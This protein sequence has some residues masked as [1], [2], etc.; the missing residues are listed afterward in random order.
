VSNKTTG[1]CY[2][3]TIK[4]S[5]TALCHMLGKP[6]FLI[7]NFKSDVQWV[8]T[9]DDGS[10]ATIYNWKDGKNYLG[11][12]GTPIVQITNWNVGGHNE[13]ALK[14]VER[15]LGRKG[16]DVSCYLCQSVFDARNEGGIEHDRFICRTCTN[17]YDDEEIEEMIGE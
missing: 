9:F 12:E 11:E 7:N 8:L 6:E 1:T 14:N 15:L 4:T 5:F 2:Q 10:I 13:R 16:D 3:G 17:N